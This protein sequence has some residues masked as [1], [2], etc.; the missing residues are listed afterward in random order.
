MMS[1][2][3]SLAIQGGRVF[4]KQLLAKTRSSA[5]MVSKSSRSGDVP[6]W[7]G[8]PSAGKTGHTGDPRLWGKTGHSDPRLYCAFFTKT[9]CF[10]SI[11]KCVCEEYR[12]LIEEGLARGRNGKAIWQDL[13]S[14][15]GFA[16][17]V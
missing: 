16:E 3:P 6:T 11:G 13:V 8:T 15:H 10:A 12:E 14:E 2:P 4:A 17:I 5:P 1:Y 7:V 9:G